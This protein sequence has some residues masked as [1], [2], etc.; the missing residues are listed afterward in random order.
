MQAREPMAVLVQR[1]LP[2]LTLRETRRLGGL[3]AGVNALELGVAISLPFT[4]ERGA[5]VG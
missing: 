5:S 2:F 4:F 1:Q 3:E